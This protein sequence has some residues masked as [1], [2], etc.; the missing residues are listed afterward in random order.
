MAQAESLSNPD[1]PAEALAIAV[2]KNDTTA[3]RRL[4]ERH[5]ELKARL[6]DA[7]PEGPFGATALLVAVHQGSREMVDLLLESGADI[8]ARSH[9]WAGSFGVLDGESPLVAYLIERGARVEAYAAARHG[10][11]DRL[12]T[13]VEADPSVVHMRGGDGQ[14]PLHVARTIEVAAFL[15]DHGADIDAL[16]VDHESTPAQYLVRE[17][18]EVARYLVSRGCRTDILLAAA[19]GDLALVRKHLELNPA[20]IQIS[21]S[22]EDFPK[23]D[24]R[25]GGTI[26]FWTLGYHKTPQMLAR[27]F[28][29]GEV[30]RFL[31]ERTP[32]VLKLALA[33]DWGDEELFG[34]LMSR[35]PDLAGT[36]SEREKKRLA[37]AA[38]NG[39]N[40]AVRLMLRAGWPLDVWGNDGG[41][42]LHWAAFHGNAEMVRE[43]LRYKPDLT[44]R[45]STYNGTALE[46]ARYGTEHSW[47]REEGD[48]PGTL[49]ELSRGV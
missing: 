17:R 28:G 35:Q 8:N 22:E 46:W 13:L 10:M 31:M 24:E 25:A 39:N 16:D 5:P 30:F 45:D 49:A 44:L 14:T 12:R 3:A 37:S 11:M 36:L 4:L 40:T 48:Y 47:K 34:T 6:N 19:L 2:E 32:D 29:H 23:R 33:C 38:Q 21:V 9:W 43:I 1:E 20:S 41:T 26:S 18:S 15:L 27:E 7:L 42:A